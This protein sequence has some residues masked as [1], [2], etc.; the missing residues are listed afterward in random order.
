EYEGLAVPEA[1]LSGDH[2][3]IERF[4][5][6]A[7]LRKCLANRPDLLSE[8]RLTKE[9]RKILDEFENKK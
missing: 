8:D 1:L 9:E 5:Q 7:A 4:R 2:A 3:R 6:A